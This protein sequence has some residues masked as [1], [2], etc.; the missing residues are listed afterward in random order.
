MLLQKGIMNIDLEKFI[1]NIKQ[2]VSYYIQTFVGVLSSP[3]STFNMLLMGAKPREKYTIIKIDKLDE[4]PIIFASISL[5]I[6]LLIGSSLSIK[7]APVDIEKQFVIGTIISYLLI[8]LLYATVL[9]AFAKW[10]GGKGKISK[11]ISGVLYVLGTLHPLLLL[12]IYVFSAI[13]PNMLSYNLALRDPAAYTQ[14][15]DWYLVDLFGFNFRLAYYIVNYILTA[16]YLYFPLSI[17]HKLSV[18]KI[19]I[20]YFIGLILL[21]LLAILSL[22][23]NPMWISNFAF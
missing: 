4:R 15:P 22:I 8:W 6:G 11:T 7:D 21:F 14:F 10:F 18:F 20:I 2:L 5:L 23:L 13:Q 3:K 19:L 12:L 17:V 16:I 1:D 9:H